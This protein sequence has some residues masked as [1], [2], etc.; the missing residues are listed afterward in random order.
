MTG[1]WRRS[2]RYL[3]LV[4]LVLALAGLVWYAREM[5]G[6]L[7]ISALLAYL[8]NPAVDLL[9]GRTRLP[10]RVAVVLVYC[11][12]LGILVAIPAIL[13]PVLLNE[14]RTLTVDFQSI[15]ARLQ[16]FLSEPITVFI[17]DVHLDRL[18][19]DIPALS[20]E[21]LTPVAEGA[22]RVLEAATKNLVWVLV[23]LVTTYYLLQ[24]WARLREWLIRLAP[25][26]YQPD[27]RRIYQ[28]ISEVW[29][30]YLRGQLAMMFV[31]AVIFA[32]V[33]LAA[34]LPG[35]LILGILTGFLDVLPDV[36]PAVAGIL[37]VVVALT[38]G[39]TYLPLPNFWFA[40]LVAAIY[41]LLMNFKNIW[42]RPRLLGRSAHLHEGVVFVAVVGALVL[43]GV[44]GALISIPVI[45]SVAVVGRYLRR[46]L[47]GMP[48]FA[49]LNE[50][51]PRGA[52]GEPEAQPEALNL[53]GK[54]RK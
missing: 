7:V 8:L 5:I 32:V 18:L 3:V 30:S 11:A 27:A 15:S 47:L 43:L 45:A 20:T 26:A 35:G 12:S 48:P 34:G 37:A 36:G 29:R 22:L 17:W 39:S 44:L 54:S 19:T 13:T 42:L 4:G 50:V 1:D 51:A 23:I 31:V 24:D 10:H 46:R 52:S 2:T 49:D 40:V 9:A 38:G 14:A 41:L 6:P 33:L 21:S 28:E 16:S 25:A 53:V